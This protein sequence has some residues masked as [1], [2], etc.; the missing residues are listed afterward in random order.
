MPKISTVNVIELQGGVISSLTSFPNN[1]DGIKEA[2]Q[3]FER[4]VRACVAEQFADD[5]EDYEYERSEQYIQDC[6]MGY[7]HS[8]DDYDVM[9]LDSTQG[10]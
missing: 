7:I 4:L 2:E 1:D 6:V 9:I 10:E 5:D 8:Y 3:M